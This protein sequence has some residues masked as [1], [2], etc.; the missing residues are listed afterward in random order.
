[1]QRS[2]AILALTDVVLLIGTAVLGMYGAHAPSDE[3]AWTQAYLRHFAAAVVAMLFTC[4]VH[5]LAFTYFVVFS[6]MAGDAVAV[7]GGMRETFDAIVGLKRRAIRWLVLGFG[8]ML[9][10]GITGVITSR[11]PFANGVPFHLAAAWLAVAANAMA[12]FGEYGLI[13]QNAAI[14]ERLFAALPRP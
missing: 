4:F 5:V 14:T 7:A 13:R 1:M 10:T 6:R 2:F 3:A 9:L 12:L 8:A 11:T